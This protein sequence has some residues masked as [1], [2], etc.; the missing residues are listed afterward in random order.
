MKYY[1]DEDSALTLNIN[2]DKIIILMKFF[3]L[4]W[5]NMVENEEKIV[6]PGD[7]LGIIEQ[8]VPGEGTYDDEG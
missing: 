4:W 2:I 1:S 5:F 7:K 8:Y 3:L 6:M